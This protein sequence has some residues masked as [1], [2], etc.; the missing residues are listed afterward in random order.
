MHPPH[1]NPVVS[2]PRVLIDRFWPLLRDPI[3][4]F[5]TA[6]SF[7]PILLIATAAAGIMLGKAAAR[8]AVIHEH[9]EPVSFSGA[10]HALLQTGRNR[11]PF[12][13]A[14]CVGLK[15]SPNEHQSLAPRRR[16]NQP[17]ASLLR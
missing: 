16:P 13:I 3:I 15:T 14:L 5:Y 1:N 8:G 17:R 6:V 9:L 4:A 12:F 2:F 11:Q 7:A 10:T